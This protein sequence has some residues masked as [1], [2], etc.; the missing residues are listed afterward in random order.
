MREETALLKAI[1]DGDD[2]ARLVYA[3]WLEDKGA[4]S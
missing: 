4:V 3:D 1:A 2:I